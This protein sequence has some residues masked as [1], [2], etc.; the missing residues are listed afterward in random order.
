VFTRDSNRGSPTT[1]TE[2]TRTDRKA[3][4]ALLT[5]DS[6]IGQR[7]YKNG[8]LLASSS[9]VGT[10]RAAATMAVQASNTALLLL[11]WG[12]VL[13]L[14]EIQQLQSLLSPVLPYKL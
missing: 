7:V 2:F 3:T 11:Y 1:S 8:A 5:W 9:S 12:R 4:S 10:Y 13:S 14:A 6:T